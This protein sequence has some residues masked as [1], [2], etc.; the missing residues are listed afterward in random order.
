[1]IAPGLFYYLLKES[2]LTLDVLTPLLTVLPPESF[3]STNLR[4]GEAFDSKR[5]PVA[6]DAAIASMAARC[7]DAPALH[8]ALQEIEHAV[9][10]RSKLRML[11]RKSTAQALASAGGNAD[12]LFVLWPDATPSD[13]AVFSE[14]PLPLEMA[15]AIQS[16]CYA[17]YNAADGLY[18]YHVHRGV[19]GPSA[20]S[21][22]RIVKQ[23][24]DA[25]KLHVEE[26]VTIAVAM[27]TGGLGASEGAN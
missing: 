22:A 24:I 9:R 2:V 3:V 16:L 14:P 11:A 20:E 21:A 7:I 1:M 4:N 17:H 15:D 23:A 26:V 13:L 12:V 25:G 19:P 18:A 10:D 6:Y 27:V 8:Q 5:W